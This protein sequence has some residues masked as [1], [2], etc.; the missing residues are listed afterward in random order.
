MHACVCVCRVN[1][2]CA[3]EGPLKLLVIFS[4]YIHVQ[5]VE[6]MLEK[7]RR[8]SKNPNLADQQ[9]FYES[10]IHSFEVIYMCWI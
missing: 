5:G 1:N 7:L 6:G 2:F 10:A 3:F 9:L 8:L 4:L